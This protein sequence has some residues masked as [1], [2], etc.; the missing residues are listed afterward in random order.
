MT[1][2]GLG[3]TIMTSAQDAAACV[4]SGSVALGC[5]SGWGFTLQSPGGGN[6]SWC[7]QPGEVAAVLM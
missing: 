2:L 7:S 5:H 6:G 3:A 4:A 1:L